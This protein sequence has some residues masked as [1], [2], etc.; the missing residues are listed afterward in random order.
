MGYDNANDAYNHL[1]EIYN[2]FVK[3][4]RIA[5]R[6]NKTYRQRLFSEMP[7]YEATRDVN[8]KRE[9]SKAFRKELKREVKNKEIRKE[10]RKTISDVLKRKLIAKR[11]NL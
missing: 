7:N 3:D 4:S 5:S 1:A 6:R 8:I 2:D 10:A 9:A 11:Y